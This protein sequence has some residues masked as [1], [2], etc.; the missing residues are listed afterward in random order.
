MFKKFCCLFMALSVLNLSVFAGVP[1]RRGTVVYVK[2]QSD[3]SSKSGSNTLTAVVDS[4][5]KA[6]DGTVVIS[7]GTPVTAN[8][9]VTKARGVGKPGKIAIK[10]M[11][12]NTVD[13]QN[14]LLYGSVNEEG[15]IKKGKALGLGI[16]L[17]CFLGP[18]FLSCLAIKGGQAMIPA[19]TVFTQFS[20]ADE[21]QIGK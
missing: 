20:T 21:Y 12:T 10:S 16:G 6:S 14:V 3:V 19:G 18:I 1:L 11:T 4:D 17:F 7:R 15:Q 9:E 5:V 2:T 8:V 13:G